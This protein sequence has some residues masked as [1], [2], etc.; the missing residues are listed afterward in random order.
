MAR[1][2]EL[3]DLTKFNMISSP[4]LSPDSSKLAFVVAKPQSDEYQ[5]TIWVIDSGNGYPIRFYSGGNPANP[6]WSPNG[7]QILFT[8][9]RDMKKDEKGT[10]LWV[11]QVWGGEPRLLCRVEGGVSQPT[12]NRYGTKVYFVSSIGE[13]D[14]EVRVID[15]IPI[16]F[17][18]EGWTYFK[19]KQ[20][21]VVDVLSG[22][23]TQLTSSDESI[24][25]YAPGNQGSKIAY[26]KPG[27]PLKPMESDLYVYDTGSGKSER[28]LCGYSIQALCWSPNDDMIAL[29]GHDGSHGYPTHWGVHVVSAQ[30]SEVK[31]LTE[32]LDRG[33]SRRHYY[34]LRS[35]YTGMAVPVWEGNEI[36]FPVSDGGN[37]GIHR[38]HVEQ[39][40]IDA[41]VTGDYSIEE[42]SVSK[43]IVAY[44]RVNT[45]KPAEV[46]VT[47]DKDICVTKFND[48]LIA[49]VALSKASRFE[50]TQKDDTTVEGW[51]LKPVG[52][53][54]GKSY[55]AILDIHGGPRSKFGDSMMFEHQLYASNGYGVIYINI[56]GSDG[57]DQKFGDI[58]GEYAV[59]D[60]EDLKKGVEVALKEFKWIDKKRLGV[61][62]LSYG[63]YMTNWAITH[64]DMF[65][66]AISQN[67][68]SNWIAFFGTSDIGFHFATEQVGGSPWSNL[69]AYI[70]KSP[71]TYA[72]D[73]ATPVLFIHSWNDYRCW[74]DQS[75]EFFTALKYLGKETQ[76][77]MFMEGQHSFRSTARP[78]IRK[79]RLQL[80]L[81]WWDKY[82]KE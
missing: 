72:G 8:S 60:Y 50:F 69:D 4:R 15:K 78:S 41:V 39:E 43:G 24:Q 52:W 59:W 13:E 11:T 25:C 1:K 74:I 61:T 55:P 6:R 10:G 67:S 30:G 70:E 80:M 79:K 31:N 2:L 18:A 45:A 82:L 27:N 36:Y 38:V 81:D 66:T 53:K 75:I 73:V 19:T 22:I 63:G 5:T 7:Q 51:V 48:H 35:P 3:D 68:I 49:N 34:D 47:E 32:S 58:R 71:I 44:T 12:W 9:R 29:L 57:Y 56:R 26:A 21:H 46:W 17:N 42:F 33:C 76:L 28:V 65:K 37:F 77:A 20:L 62:G 16:W 14:P 23:V 40:H 64:T 54:K